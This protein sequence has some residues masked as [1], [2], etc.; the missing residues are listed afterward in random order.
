[1]D[2]P[3]LHEEKEQKQNLQASKNYKCKCLDVTVI[4]Y[5]LACSNVFSSVA[6]C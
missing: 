4:R 3:K 2:W 1:M 6:I 5:L